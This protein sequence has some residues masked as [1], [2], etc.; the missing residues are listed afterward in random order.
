MEFFGAPAEPG[1]EIAV[2]LR[3]DMVIFSHGRLVGAIPVARYER[4][5]AQL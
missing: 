1:K 2:F 4:F 5:I 3:V